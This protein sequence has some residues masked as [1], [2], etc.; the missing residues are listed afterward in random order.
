VFI[1]I[2]L[3]PFNMQAAHGTATPLDDKVKLNL[4]T[5]GDEDVD[6]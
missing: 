4:A 2:I 1:D 6:P 3:K 5:E